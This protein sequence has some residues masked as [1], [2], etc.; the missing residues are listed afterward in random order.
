M[1]HFPLLPVFR[2]CRQPQSFAPILGLEKKWATQNC[3]LV[4]VGLYHHWY[5]SQPD[6]LRAFKIRAP[7]HVKCEKEISVVDFT[8]R[9]VSDCLHNKFDDS[10]QGDDEDN[11]QGPL[12][13]DLSPMTDLKCGPHQEDESSTA[14]KATSKNQ[15]G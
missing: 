15:H 1:G 12:F 9:V 5:H 13:N 14:A 7:I 2:C 10:N 4:Q 11:Q 3:L 6:S 8:E